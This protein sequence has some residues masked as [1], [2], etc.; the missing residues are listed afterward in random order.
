MIT[1]IIKILILT[2][3]TTHSTGDDIDN[4][5]H[6]NGVNIIDNQENYDETIT[7]NDQFDIVISWEKHNPNDLKSINITEKEINDRYSNNKE[8]CYSLMLLE[9]YMWVRKIFIIT[10]QDKDYFINWMV[11]N[12]FAKTIV[13]IPLHEIGLNLNCKSSLAIECSLWKIN[14][15]SNNFYYLNDDFL[16]GPSFIPSMTIYLS[17]FFFKGL[18]P[19]LR[20]INKSLSDYNSIY[21][22]KHNLILGHYPYLI[23]KNTA[24]EI[25][26]TFANVNITQR[27][28]FRD[29]STDVNCL[30]LSSLRMLDNN[31]VTYKLRKDT[32]DDQNKI[33]ST[34]KMG[35]WDSLC[36]QFGW[37]FNKS[38]HEFMSKLGNCDYLD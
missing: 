30:L 12:K 17:R 22:T 26:Q 9:K 6:D 29:Y 32:F 11:A 37:K 21:R 16:I 15:L 4:M 23:N 36:M 28:L 33:M 14:G 24:K 7:F 1:T 8:I 31:L 25:S 5:M 10:N 35:H 13:L 20:F 18:D 38:F 34:I 2:I 27:H 19:Y 3:M